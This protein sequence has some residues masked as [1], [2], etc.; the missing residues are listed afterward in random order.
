MWLQSIGL[1]IKK[2]HL[3][4]FPQQ[5]FG[6]VQRLCILQVHKYSHYDWFQKQIKKAA[7]I[8]LKKP[9]ILVPKTVY[10]ISRKIASKLIDTDDYISNYIIRF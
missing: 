9:M 1:G 10:K 6:D 8:N 5:L 2:V 7:N 3:A 4:S